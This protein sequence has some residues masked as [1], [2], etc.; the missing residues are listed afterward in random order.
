MTGGARQS[1]SGRVVIITG[2]SSG[3]GRE[4]ALMLAGDGARLVLAARDADALA[5]VAERC[6][7]SGAQAIAVPTDVTREA[8]CAQLIETARD[9]F[10]RIDVVL[11]AAGLGSWA[12]FGDV[13]DLAVMQQLM[14]VN[15]WGVVNPVWH[16]LP[17]LRASDG[18]VV[19]IS[20]VQGF[21]GVPWHSGYAAA[22]HAVEGFCASLRLEEGPRVAVMT[23]RAHWLSGTGLRARALTADGTQQ[24]AQARAHGRDAVPVE[25]AAR[26]IIMALGKR[27]RTLWIP[28]HMRALNQLAV[29]APRLVDRIIL[30]RMARED[31]RATPAAGNRDGGAA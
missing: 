9:H 1:S 13:T 26:R 16:A 4:L 17:H 23:V 15:Y 12:R 29:L 24:G 18:Q 19:A 28:R 3:L 11:A 8:A 25:E 6:A 5:E 30:S 31:G 21:L 20:S 2:A 7:R 22:K 27:R 14:A 10:G